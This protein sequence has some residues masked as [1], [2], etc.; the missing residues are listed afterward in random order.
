M[1]G[2]DLLLPGDMRFKQHGLAFAVEIVDTREPAASAEMEAELVVTF[3]IAEWRDVEN[4]A[5]SQRFAGPEGLAFHMSKQIVVRFAEGVVDLGQHRGNASVCL[6]ANPEAH[7]IENVAQ[8]S[9][10]RI[11]ND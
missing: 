7:G 5:C 4:L 11:Q 10:K 3:Y 8:H 2:E 6:V 9:R 1:G